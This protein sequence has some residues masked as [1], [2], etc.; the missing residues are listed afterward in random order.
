[1]SKSSGI[2][3]IDDAILDSLSMP[4]GPVPAMEA[5]PLESLGPSLR[6][7]GGWDEIDFA[8]LLQLKETRFVNVDTGYRLRHYWIPATDLTFRQT[9]VTTPQAGSKLRIEQILNRKLCRCRADVIVWRD[10][11]RGFAQAGESYMPVVGAGS[12][13]NT[14]D[15]IFY[16]NRSERTLRVRK[17]LDQGAPVPQD[18]DEAR[19]NA[20]TSL[21]FICPVAPV[22]VHDSWTCEAAGGSMTYRVVGQRKIG[23]T[24]AVV[25]ERNGLFRHNTMRLVGGETCCVPLRMRR[26]GVTVF[27][28]NRAVVLEDRLFDTCVESPDVMASAVGM[29]TCSIMRLIRSESGNAADGHVS[30]ELPK[31]SSD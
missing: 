20:I 28:F 7:S 8:K 30:G 25:I 3:S 9:I 1:M 29:T 24:N 2:S 6:N 19:L 4:F 26:T 10:R 21:P 27:A 13:S 5:D 11:W 12:E 22:F 18:P 17:P 16:Y 23:E 31:Y 14:H 15:A